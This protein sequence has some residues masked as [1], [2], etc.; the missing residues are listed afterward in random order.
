MKAV[1]APL[2]RWLRAKGA[3]MAGAGVALA[4]YAS[5]AAADADRAVLQ[6]AAVMAFG[7]GVAIAALARPRMP[8]VAALAVGLL[9]AGSLVFAGALTWRVLGGGSSA[10][11]PFGGGMMILGWLLYAA[12][13]LED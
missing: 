9:L 12:S 7:H 6:A 5:H 13:P 4:A 10:A 3:L 2:V 8:R 1:P 11:A